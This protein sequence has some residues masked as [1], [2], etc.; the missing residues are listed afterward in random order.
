MKMNL[1]VS[2]DAERI[3]RVG[4]R[5]AGGRQAVAT[6]DAEEGY[7]H[8]I[9]E[10]SMSEEKLQATRFLQF[11]SSRRLTLDK[12]KNLSLEEQ[13]RLKKEFSEVDWNK[14]RQN[15]WDKTTLSE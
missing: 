10:A 3:E 8:R 13:K 6:F 12:V 14:E 4:L 15:E 11:L 1:F 9:D 5:G 2:N 7:I